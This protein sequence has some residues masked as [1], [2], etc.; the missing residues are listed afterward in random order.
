MNNLKIVLNENEEIVKAIR[1]RLK[2]TNNQ[3][4][5]LPETEWN[6]NTKCPCKQFREQDTI[7]PCHCNLYIKIKGND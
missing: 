6:E 1:N 7:G 5:C 4:P 3:C 2:V